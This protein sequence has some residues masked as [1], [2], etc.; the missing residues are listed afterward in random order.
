[1]G[2][3]TFYKANKSIGLAF[4]SPGVQIVHVKVIL[5][6]ENDRYRCNIYV[7]T[8]KTVSILRTCL[9][10]KC[11][12]NYYLHGG[13]YVH[14]NMNKIYCFIYKTYLAFNREFGHAIV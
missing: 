11:V 4:H 3:H 8:F 2:F 13:Q 12:E 7:M 6:S 9:S 10:R 14:E 5:T 1:M